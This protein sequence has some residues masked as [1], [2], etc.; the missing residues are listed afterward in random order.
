MAHLADKL[1]QKDNNTIDQN[2]EEYCAARQ[3]ISTCPKFEIQH[4]R[5]AKTSVFKCPEPGCKSTFCRRYRFKRHMKTHTKEESFKCWVPGCGRF[6]NRKDNLNAHY[7]KTHSKKG[8][9]NRYVSTLDKKSPDYDPA[10]RGQLTSEGRPIL[11]PYVEASP[12]T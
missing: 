11:D 4:L 2:V 10:F 7:T 1:L 3:K 5:K 6:I 8:G 9:R 12:G